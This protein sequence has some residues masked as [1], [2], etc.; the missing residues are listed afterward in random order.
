MSTQHFNTTGVRNGFPLPV[1]DLDVS[2]LPWW[3][4]LSGVNKDNVS[5]FS[6][7]DLNA[8][9]AVSHQKA[10]ELF[11]ALKNVYGE[12][13]ARIDWSSGT[14]EVDLDASYPVRHW[15]SGDAFSEPFERREE[16][17]V[18]ELRTSSGLSQAAFGSYVARASL[19]FIGPVGGPVR[20]LNGGAFVGYGWG[21]EA[22]AAN[23]WEGIS[24]RA[25]ANSIYAM[26]GSMLCSS[27]TSYFEDEAA[28]DSEYE[29]DV[30]YVEMNGYHFTGV[31]WAKGESTRSVNLSTLSAEATGTIPS[32]TFEASSKVNDFDFYETFI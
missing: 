8:E 23:L 5:S 24:A 11:W 27:T 16:A 6:S 17:S 2:S 20:L 18:L 15:S 1:T 9:I 4:T 25:V 14:A 3:T 29:A 19:G 26:A 32:V 28:S 12:G 13:N 30:G 21:D 7:E 31:V 10:A 22:G